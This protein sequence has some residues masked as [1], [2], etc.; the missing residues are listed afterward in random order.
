MSL[1]SELA[2]LE[3]QIEQRYLKN[4]PNDPLILELEEKAN[5]IA[6]E[7]SQAEDAYEKAQQKKQEDERYKRL[8][9]RVQDKYNNFADWLVWAESLYIIHED[10][11]VE[12]IALKW[13]EQKTWITS[14]RIEALEKIEQLINY[15]EYDH[16]TR[17]RR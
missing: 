17:K 14:S 10:F 3:Y 6:D 1:K 2:K 11:T 5:L 8:K 15:K 16:F 13:S 4:G 12:S 9:E 7:I